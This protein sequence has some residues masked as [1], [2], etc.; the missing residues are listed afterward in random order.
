M[1]LLTQVFSVPLQIQS[2]KRMY[3][4]LCRCCTLPAILSLLFIEF[5]GRYKNIVSE[6]L[7]LIKVLSFLAWFIRCSIHSTPSIGQKM[8]SKNL[9][10]SE[11]V[12]TLIKSRRSIFCNDMDPE[13]S[14]PQE[15]IEG[16][17]EA[18]NWAPSH[19][20]SKPWHFVVFTDPSQIAEL[21]HI[22]L[23][24]IQN[25]KG[26]AFSSKYQSDFDENVRW[27]R[28]KALIA[29]VMKRCSPQQRRNPEWEEIAACGCAVQN[30]HLYAT[31][32]PN[33]CAYWSSWY[34]SA[35][36]ASAMKIF[37]GASEDDRILGFFIVGASV[38]KRT[39][40]RSFQSKLSSEWR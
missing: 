28:A 30:I 9:P 23:S 34:E 21:K 19:G 18:A 29:I 33:I 31:S 14:V 3:L 22:S 36:K 40:Y 39:R 26:Y 35:I 32:L 10:S 4:G 1:K 20:R 15:H 38:S 12:M 5:L 2:S 11:E 6:I 37:L 17:L 7:F 13:A 25:A 8:D 27:M 16:M 24:C